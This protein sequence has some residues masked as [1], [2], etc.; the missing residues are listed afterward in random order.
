MKYKIVIQNPQ[1]VGKSGKSKVFSPVEAHL[2]AF[3]GYN[4]DDIPFC[5][6]DQDTNRELK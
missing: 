5:D 3:A 1:W 2:I 6:Y 4:L